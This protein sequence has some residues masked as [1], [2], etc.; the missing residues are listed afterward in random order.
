MRFVQFFP[1]VSETVFPRFRTLLCVCP[2]HLSVYH[3][4]KKAPVP[5]S[6]FRSGV[7]INRRRA[8]AGYSLFGRV[9][10]VGLSRG[11]SAISDEPMWARPFVRGAQFQ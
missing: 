10:V 9:E 6:F 4:G 8:D 2:C 1:G 5:R 3:A 11:D 7:R